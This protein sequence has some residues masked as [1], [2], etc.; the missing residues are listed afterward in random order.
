MKTVIIILLAL[1]Y[2]S[3]GVFSQ[4]LIPFKTIDTL[5]F[6]V[7]YEL[8]FQPDSTDHRTFSEMMILLVGNQASIF[9]GYNVFR[10]DSIMSN[11]KNEADLQSFRQSR[12]RQ[13]ELVPR[14]LYR[15]HKNYPTGKTTFTD[16]IM[17]DFF[18]YSE[19]YANFDWELTD[20]KKKY[21]RY[22]TQK[23]TTYY[24]GRFWEAWFTTS[25]PIMEGPYK[26]AGLP[27]LILELVDSDNY[28]RFSLVSIE[29]IV[30]KEHIQLPLDLKP[31][32]I[33]REQFLRSY[34]V[35]TQNPFQA[36]EGLIE[37]DPLDIE[38][39]KRQTLRRNNP[40]ELK[41]D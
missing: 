27:G 10:Y 26:F 8:T 30:A 18:Q 6:R 12:M 33:T 1:L 2:N 39:R 11:I 41:A 32:K 23:A 5:Q 36:M 21:Q 29:K 15:I 38:I 28:Y 13:P 22:N 31:I 24:G 7:K 19:E 4:S 35:Y 34:L 25:L 9:M 20:E 40:I 14:I 3:S 37:A 17:P 16:I